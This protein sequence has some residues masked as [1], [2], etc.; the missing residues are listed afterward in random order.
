MLRKR[1][2]ARHRN[3]LESYFP[4][5]DTDV[6]PIIRLWVLRALVP[7]GGHRQFIRNSHYS[8]D[9]LACFLGLLDDELDMD[10]EKFGDLQNFNQ[11]AALTHLRRQHREAERSASHGQIP[12]CLQQN[13]QQLSEL[14]ALST[15]DT[16][17]MT[18]AILVHSDIL[19]DAATNQFEPMNTGQ[20]LQKLAGLL[21]LPLAEVRHALSPEGQL[22]RCG[23][24][25]LDLAGGRSIKD[26]LDLPSHRFAD[27]LTSFRTSPLEL[28]S[29][30][31][32]T[33]PPSE[34]ALADYRHLGWVS[35]L[36]LPYLATCLA[37]RRSGVNIML[38]GLPGTGKTQLARVLAQELGSSLFEVA[39]QDESGDGMTSHARFAAYRSAQFLLAQR[40]TLLLFDEAEDIFSGGVQWSVRSSWPGSKSAAQSHKAWTNHILE[41]NTIPT[42]WICNSIA[43]LDPS[44][45]RRF[46]FIEEVPVPSRARRLDIIQSTTDDLVCDEHLQR[47]ADGSDLV[48]AVVNRAVNVVRTIQ[49]TLDA[50]AR[51]NAV[52]RLVSATLKAQGHSPLPSV[53]HYDPA[54]EY[55]PA[56]VRTDADLAIITSRLASVHSARLCL[57]GPPGTGK[58][59]YGYWLAK[60]LNKPLMLKRASD[61]LSPYVG[62]SEKNI[63]Q[64]FQAAQCEDAVL[65]IDEIDSFLQSRQQAHHSWEITQVNE[66]LVQMEAFSGIFIAST[67]LMKDLD[68]ASLRRFDLK[69]Q[70]DYLSPAQIEAMARKCCHEIGLPD[71]CSA[72]VVLLRKLTKLTPGD[73]LVMRRQHRFQPFQDVDGLIYALW[74]EQ[75]L[76]P[77]NTAGIGFM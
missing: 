67:N 68:S 37:Q 54:H 40:T 74:R 11:H 39:H 20:A 27:R 41:S 60:Q 70:F 45:V 6:A 13:I 71:L 36:L 62:G 56:L 38:Y 9:A 77:V 58:T 57:Y 28:M 43:E 46:D 64:T 24:L 32:R 19:L 25:T 12:D 30:R 14:M 63:A 17:L 61:L 18:F 53:S 4:A 7:L 76:K 75:E 50:D 73:F 10:E 31:I 15:T 48:P 49:D 1:V 59:A 29:D 35:E 3:S 33:T 52:V 66:M 51:S 8:D 47:M 26:M 72:D 69:I 34:L 23:L 55:D 2:S 42:L 44:F 16:A 65:M 5:V 22:S 21:Q